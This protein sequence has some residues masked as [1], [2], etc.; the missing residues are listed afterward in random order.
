MARK[1]RKTIKLRRFAKKPLKQISKQDPNK[2]VFE[3]VHKTKIRII[4]IGSG[5]ISIVSEI[6]AK[7]KKVDFVAAN[8]DIRSFKSLSNKIKKFQFGQNLTKGLGTGMNV[9][10]GEMAAREEKEKIKKLF[11]NQ[12]FCIIVSCLGGGTGGGSTQV[13][14]KI[15]KGLGCLTYGI[16]TLPFSFEGERKM[17]IAKEALIKLK[18]YFNIFSVIPNERIFEIID[19]NTPL[20]EALSAINKRLVEN[21]EGLL[22]MIYGSGVIN[23]DFADL[24]TILLG[25]GKLSY[26]NAVRI[27]DAHKEETAKNIISTSLY[28]YSFKG[29]KGIL[30]NI[31]GG[32]SLCLSEVSRISGIISEMANKNAKIIFGINQDGKFKNNLQITLLAVGCGVKNE[33]IGLKEKKKKKIM[34]IAKLKKNKIEKTK[35]KNKKGIVKKA[36]QTL[37]AVIK[38]KPEEGTKPFSEIKVRRNA[39][40]VK[41]VAE[42]EE[43]ELLEKESA[44]EIPAILRKK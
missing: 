11:E 36:V 18:P 9:E 32:K 5:G 26:L 23:I 22:E 1:K 3:G 20:Q 40:E 7:I 12:D 28:P 37:P 43:K 38:E 17:E 35:I 4:G 13:F 2:G 30:Y 6:S 21:I 15:A 25:Y 33:L 19:K 24:R 16:F 34:K 31:C 8:T 42:E 14:A 29:A 10:L 41:K 27:E 39:L 44:W